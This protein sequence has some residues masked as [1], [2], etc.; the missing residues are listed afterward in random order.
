[1]AIIG[2]GYI[3]VELAGVLQALGSQ[4]D[5][6]VRDQ[7]LLRQ[8]DAEIVEQLQENYRQQGVALEF[9][10]ALKALYRD[11][12]G[13]LRLEAED[14]SMR[15]GYDQVLFATGRRPNT[16]D[17]GLDT[18]GITPDANGDIPVD[19]WQATPAPGVYAVGDIC[20]CGPALTPVAIAA[21]RRPT[22]TR[23]T[24]SG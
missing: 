20:G 3:A 7:R 18:V 5:V 8:G 11:G 14:G 21:A 9:G 2:G 19:A 13:R 16:G 12:D 22:A 10:Y 24:R 23:C 15:D 17:I 6:Y 4:V 1:M